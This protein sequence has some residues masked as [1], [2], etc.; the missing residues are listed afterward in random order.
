M[1]YTVLMYI[2]MQPTCVWYVLSVD[3]FSLGSPMSM[4]YIHMQSSKCFLL[5]FYNKGEQL[6]STV[7]GSSLFAEE[8]GGN[9]C[10]FFSLQYDF[11]HALMII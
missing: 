5:T 2:L 10:C 9:D 8:G 3:C 4:H 1:V 11:F 6:Y 7:C